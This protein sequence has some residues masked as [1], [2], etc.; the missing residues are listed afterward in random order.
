MAKKGKAKAAASK[1]KPASKKAAAATKPTGQGRAVVL[2]NGTRRIDYI[3]EQY[4]TKGKTRSEIK[5]AINKMLPE[6]QEIAYQIV[7]AGTKTK[8]DPR[9]ARE[10]A[11]V[12]KAKAAAAKA[13]ADTKEK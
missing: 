4:Y 5:N 10:K 6:G 3:H 11:A 9:I 1:A 12:V 8:E 2:P 7:F 13:K